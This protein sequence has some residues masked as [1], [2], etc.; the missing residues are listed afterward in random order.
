MGCIQIVFFHP[1]KSLIKQFHSYAHIRAGE[2]EAQRAQR[3]ETAELGSDPLRGSCSQQHVHSLALPAACLA[4]NPP[5]QALDNTAAPNA[6]AGS[7][8]SKTVAV[9][10]SFFSRGKLI[11]LGKCWPGTIQCHGGLSAEPGKGLSVFHGYAWDPMKILFGLSSRQIVF[12]GLSWKPEQ[13]QPILRWPTPACP[14]P[15]KISP[16]S[17]RSVPTLPS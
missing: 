2:T 4:V 13:R 6:E 9:H 16:D 11:A 7:Q 12:K 17:C 14:L 5:L 1:F 15:Y 8:A 3:E 10:F